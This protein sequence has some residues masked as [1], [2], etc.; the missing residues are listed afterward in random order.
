MRPAG[1]SRRLSGPC[2]VSHPTSA[3]PSPGCAWRDEVAQAPF[4]MQPRTFSVV[5]TVHWRWTWGCEHADY[6]QGGPAS[7]GRAGQAAEGRDLAEGD[8]A[9]TVKAGIGPQIL[10]RYLVTDVRGNAL[11]TPA[12]HPRYVLLRQCCFRHPVS[13][14]KD[15]CPQ[16][17]G[18]IRRRPA[19]PSEAG[20][21]TAGI[22][23]SIGFHYR[24]TGQRDANF[25]H[26]ASRRVPHRRHC[27]GAMPGPRPLQRMRCSHPNGSAP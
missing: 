7:A 17:T 24:R 27:R 19:C 6:R 4:E 2:G 22:Y 12:P 9:W 3:Q 11:L 1:G 26:A 8:V 23:L 10:E 20:V 18:A 16:R 15:R 21:Q 25:G 5:A 13:L 14:S